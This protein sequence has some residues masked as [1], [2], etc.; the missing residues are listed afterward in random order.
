[1]YKTPL[2]FLLL[3]FSSLTYAQLNKDVFPLNR[4]F[5]RGGLY[6]S[7]QL[8]TSIGSKSDGNYSVVDTNYA[9]TV[10][11][12]GKLAY[13]LEVGWFHSFKNPL[14]IHY[15]EAGLSYRLFKG[16]ATHDGTLSNPLGS[17][18]FLSDNNFSNQYIVASLRAVNAKQLGKWTFL[19]TALGVNFNYE[20]GN[21]YERSAPY[22]LP[23]E[24][25]LGQNSLQVHL[26]LGIGFRVSRQLIIMPTIESP[27]ITAYPTDDINPAFPFFSTN[28]QPIIIGLKFFFLREDPE[29]CNAPTYKGLQH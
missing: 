6:I 19:S 9:Y 5:K 27:L 21:S 12:K 14:L 29:N 23:E 7:P 25:F 10:D 22:P 18:N 1:M 8:T 17:R 24:E 11:G 3:I 4:G 20:L 28:Y 26:Q 2:F 13:G 15:L 16:E